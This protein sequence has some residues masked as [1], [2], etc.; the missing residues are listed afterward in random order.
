MDKKFVILCVVLFLII[1]I[2]VVVLSQVQRAEN[3][4]RMNSIED[5]FDKCMFI[6]AK[7]V[8]DPIG[9]KK[10]TCYEKCENHYGVN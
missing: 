8:F 1:F 7:F 2:T 4:K 9:V 10:V 3:T 6:C 5:G